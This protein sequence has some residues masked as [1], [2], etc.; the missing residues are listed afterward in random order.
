MCSADE[1]RYLFRFVLGYPGCA[2][3]NPDFKSLLRSC[4]SGWGR[5]GITFAPPNCLQ[6]SQLIIINFQLTNEFKSPLASFHHAS[7]TYLVPDLL[8]KM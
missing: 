6:K 1:S 5:P 7:E 8:K 3:G 2:N 4:R